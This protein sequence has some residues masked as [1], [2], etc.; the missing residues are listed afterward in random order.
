MS[1]SPPGRRERKKAQTRQ[2]LAEHALR[3][4]TERGYDDV[5]VA[6][7][8]DAA[9]VSVSTLFQYFRSKESLVFDGEETIEAGFVAAVRERAPGTP[10]LDAL[11][12]FLLGPPDGS[13]GPSPELVA[14]IERT[15]VLADHLDRIW[16]WRANV[17]ASALAE[18]VGA[19][20]DDVRIRALARYVVLVVPITRTST[21]RRGDIRVIFDH[22]RDG[23]GPM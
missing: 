1:T 23:W 13:V 6:E 5:T 12:D 18:S 21:D 3:L 11:R 22:L 8:A 10:V 14:L 2:A 7:V 19:Q 16:A 9:D 17:L 4:F 15:P 20:P